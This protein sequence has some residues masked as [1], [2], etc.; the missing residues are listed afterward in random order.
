MRHLTAEQIE[1]YAEGITL[2]PEPHLASCLRCQLSVAQERTMTLALSKLEP[3]APSRDFAAG[4]DGALDVVR[5][6]TE[7]RQSNQIWVGV[8]A[9]SSLLML[10]VFGYQAIMAFQYGGA[11]DFLSL[12]ASRPD[13]ISRYP[14]EAVAALVESL[15]LLETV[16]SL[17]LLILAVVL[18]QQFVGIWRSSARGGSSK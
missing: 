7:D 13:L 1:N 8:A 15:P 14:T 9:F 18:G 10:M 12:Y 4:L 6:V 3:I 17:G 5:R 2:E 11:L 16:L